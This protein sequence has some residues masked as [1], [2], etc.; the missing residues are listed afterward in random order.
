MKHR[1][2]F[3]FFIV[4]VFFYSLLFAKIFSFYPHSTPQS[5][6]TKLLKTFEDKK[7]NPQLV[8]TFIQLE[9]EKKTP[10]LSSL[11]SKNQGKLTQKEGYSYYNPIRYL[12][13]NE[14]V[15]KETQN[16]QKNHK[17][18]LHQESQDQWGDLSALSSPK[19]SALSH[20]QKQQTP[21][22]FDVLPNKYV[23]EEVR[24]NLS[25]DGFVGIDAQKSDFAEYLIEV[26]K[27]VFFNW[28]DFIP[29]MQ[30]DQNLIKTN[31]SGTIE[32]TLVI[33][34]DEEHKKYTFE[35]LAPFSSQTM[36]NLTQRSFLYLTLPQAPQKI[37]INTLI[38]RLNVHP[39]TKKATGEFKF[40]Y[41]KEK[42]EWEK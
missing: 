4:S 28:V 41:L 42:K 22:P 29:A 20:V 26:A 11:Q 17:N 1:G 7:E 8:E 37:Q 16:P 10:N 34:F 23:Q 35:F 24:I 2:L 27:K 25:S 30:I 18:L 15:P 36:N 39:L 9:H 32:A 21:V 12:A 38:M 14:S 5:L 6:A 3:Y 40:D 33:Y 19:D 13:L 31:P